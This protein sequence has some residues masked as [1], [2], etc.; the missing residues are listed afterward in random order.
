MALRIEVAQRTS[1]TNIGLWF[2]AALAAWDFGYL[3]ADE[4][5]E[6]CAGTMRTL[7]RMERFDTHL[8]N[9]YDTRTLDPLTP[10]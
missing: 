10:R 9:W 3:T 5:W 6:R 1:P 4:M 8:L 7:D 2:T